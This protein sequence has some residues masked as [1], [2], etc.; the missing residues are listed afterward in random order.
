MT[1]GYVEAVGFVLLLP[2]VAF[3]ARALGR[4]TDT[5]GWAAQTAFAGGVGYVFVSLAP[6]LAA[7]AAAL[8]GAHHGAD[9]AAV[10]VVNDVRSFAFF[11]SMPLL[12]VHAVGVG[13]SALADR[14]LPAW[15][16]WWGVATG[17]VLVASVPAA[18]TGAVDIATL[19][20]TVWF[21]ALAGSM[22]AHRPAGSVAPAP[23]ITIS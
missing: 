13:I 6:G 15:V 18:S 3:L 22:I 2:V 16:A 8:Y 14:V 21:V 19:L 23:R 5:G 20:W 12:A 4:R 10:S 9:L 7:G 1:G 11:L 17:I